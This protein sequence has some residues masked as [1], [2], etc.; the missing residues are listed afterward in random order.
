M[1]LN[2]P[3]FSIVMPTRDRAHLLNFAL[4]SALA[5]SFDDYEIL[6]S[7][8]CSID[9]TRQVVRDLADERVRYVRT[10]ERLSMP[11]NWE[12]A[13]EHARGKYVTYLSD[14]DALRPS[15]LEK[16]YT[17]ISSVH[18]TSIGWKHGAYH[19]PDSPNE[20]ERCRLGLP[21]FTRDIQEIPSSMI[22]EKMYALDYSDHY[23]RLINSC[24]AKAFLE[25]R[26][27]RMGKLF[28]PIAPDYSVAV[29]TL[30]GMERILFI[31]EPLMIGGLA[32]ASMGSYSFAESTA[33]QTFI[34]E[35][36]DLE[37]IWR[38][39]LSSPA[40]PNPYNHIAVTLLNLK[41]ILAEELA[42]YSL[43]IDK[44]FIHEYQQAKVM[45]SRGVD[46]RQT[47][48]DWN[49]A[50]ADQSADVQR[51]VREAISPQD[52][53][54][55]TKAIPSAQG[56]AQITGHRLKDVIQKLRIVAQKPFTTIAQARRSA[57]SLSTEQSTP[58][59]GPA[60]EYYDN[61][62]KPYDNILEATNA[63]EKSLRN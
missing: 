54:E 30:T 46:V 47:L 52:A 4:Q 40:S 28:V 34:N 11:N 14:D 57:N 5:Q 50:L 15:L 32:G 23:P 7:D 20:R 31:D 62:M 2:E 16:L 25:E 53:A 22:L 35:F 29:A 38:I 24:T 26:K 21:L 27:R 42:G 10:E 19:H 44:L 36:S 17:I 39:P 59:E 8:N 48:Q 6:V 45:E 56:V 1:G 13:L 12:F 63:V 49:E 60:P 3:F 55:T 18:N 58:K 51:S 37:R 33:H 61:I 9:N 41:E 43:S